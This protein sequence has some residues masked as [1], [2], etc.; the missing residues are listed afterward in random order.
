MS[1]VLQIMW[2]AD[3]EKDEK[4]FGRYVKEYDPFIDPRT[5]TYKLVVVDDAV[6]ALKFISGIEALNY[7]NRICPNVPIRW[8]D[9]RPNRPLT[10]YTCEIKQD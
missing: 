9:G 8:W 1:F 2:R 7:W 3:G 4:V 6:D 5:D 10:A